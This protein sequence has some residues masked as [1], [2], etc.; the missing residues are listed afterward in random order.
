MGTP[1]TAEL[2]GYDAA[3]SELL[4]AMHIISNQSKNCLPASSLQLS[5]KQEKHS[6]SPEMEQIQH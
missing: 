4:D 1:A 5:G 3:E 2:N 6:K